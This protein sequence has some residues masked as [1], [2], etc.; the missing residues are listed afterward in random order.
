M[1]ETGEGAGAIVEKKGL[2]QISDTAELE[3]IID[4]VLGENP[5]AVQDIKGGKKQAFGFIVGQVMRKT[6]GKANPQVIHKLLA[7]KL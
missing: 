6:K 7:G 2:R 4:Q 5:A 3:A 1:I